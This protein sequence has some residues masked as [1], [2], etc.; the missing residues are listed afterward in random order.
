MKT[1]YYKPTGLTAKQRSAFWKAFSASCSAQGLTADA[2]EPYRKQIMLELCGVEHMAQLNRTDHYDKLLLRLA[3]DSGDYELAAR[4][5]SGQERRLA[6]MVEVTAMQLMQCQGTDA[7]SA[8]SYVA[9]IVEQ[10]GF[11]VRQDGTTY[12]MDLIGGQIHALFVALDTHRRRL[13][14]RAGWTRRL[15]FDMG[16]FY[17]RRTDGTIELIFLQDPPPNYFKVN[18]RA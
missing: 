5:Q 2:R 17:G 18:I 7:A 9:G 3:T 15:K 12:W 10:A 4:Y 14:S 1:T 11:N 16:S 13:L 8:S 6:K